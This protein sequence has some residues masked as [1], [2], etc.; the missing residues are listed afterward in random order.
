[1][2]ARSVYSVNFLM[3]W[4]PLTDDAPY[5]SY[6]VSNCIVQGYYSKSEEEHLDPVL[7]N[8]PKLGPTASQAVLEAGLGDQASPLDSVYKFNVDDFPKFKATSTKVIPRQ[9]DTN[10]EPV[11]NGGDIVRV[12]WNDLI[13]KCSFRDEFI[14]VSL[15]HNTSSTYFGKKESSVTSVSF[16]C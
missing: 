1:M 8:L 4:L 6:V 14:P 7:K 3:D 16:S 12:S 13:A 2:S 9:L 15:V 11:W 10:G 5:L